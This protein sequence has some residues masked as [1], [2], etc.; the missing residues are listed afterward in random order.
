MPTPQHLVEA[1]KGDSGT[2]ALGEW[3]LCVHAAASG[4]YNIADTLTAQG[5]FALRAVGGVSELGR[6]AQDELRWAK[7]EFIAAWRGWKPTQ[8]LALP[9]APVQSARLPESVEAIAVEQMRELTRA[10]VAQWQS[11]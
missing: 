8:R 3:E 6:I 2:Q 5:K 11:E 9:P 10:S 7:K 4:D 1:I